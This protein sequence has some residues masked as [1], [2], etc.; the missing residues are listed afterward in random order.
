MINVFIVT[1]TEMTVSKDT[2]KAT[3]H[4]AIKNYQ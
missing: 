3:P 2:I 4:N 1:P